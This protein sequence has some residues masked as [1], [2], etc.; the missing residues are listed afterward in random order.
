MKSQPA[1]TIFL[2]ENNL[3]ERLPIMW[4]WLCLFVCLFL[5][6]N[7]VSLSLTSQGPSGVTG[8]TGS[9]GNP[10]ERVSSKL[11]IHLHGCTISHTNV[12][13]SRVRKVHEDLPAILEGQARRG[14][15]ASLG[16]GG[17]REAKEREEIGE[18]LEKPGEMDQG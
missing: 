5:F 6:P 1:N 18:T 10:G 8:N 9:P 17:L 4:S 7:S 16:R 2:P 13:T 15:P 14:T 3:S 11:L 12:N